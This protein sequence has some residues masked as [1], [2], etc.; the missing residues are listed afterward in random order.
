VFGL[1]AAPYI[2]VQ[3]PAPEGAT[4]SAGP[5]TWTDGIG[6]WTWPG[7]EGRPLTVEVYSDADEVELH[8]DGRALGRLPAGP[9]HRYRATF[10]VD[11]RPGELTAVAIRAGRAAESHSVRTATGAPAIRLT[12]D[13][14][15]ISPAG[16]DLVFLEIE[17]VDRD[18]TLFTSEEHAVT[19]EVSGPGALH[20]LGSAN[21]APE[22]PYSAATHP[23]FDGRALA[24]VRGTGSGEIAI[25]VTAEG[26]DPATITVLAG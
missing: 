13:R 17:F 12:A 15:T 24:V 26:M 3:R 23:A 8:L 1:R 4:L 20:A 2:A 19:V 10:T 16:T 22:Q 14:H 25:R 6:S 5:W 18:G 21:P 7:S 9:Q 11:Y